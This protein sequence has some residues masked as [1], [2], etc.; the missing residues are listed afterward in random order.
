VRFDLQSH[1]TRSDG[2]LSP[3]EVVA[4]AR[5]AGVEL[6]SLTDHDGVEGVAEAAV[7]AQTAGIDLVRGVEI[8][9]AEDE[10]GDLHV[11]GY[12]I[13]VR[14]EPL[15]ARLAHSRGERSSRA[16]RMADALR[17]LGFSIDEDAASRLAGADGTVGRPHLAQAI[18]SDPRNRARLAQEG[19][20]DASGFL[21][22]Y[23]IEGK[24]AFRGRS[25]PSVAE[26]IA[27][28]H[29]AGG[30]A[31]WAHPF[32]D[33][34]E[35]D[36]VV[37]ALGRFADAGLDGVEAFYITHTREQ[38]LLLARECS[39]LGL[40]STGSSDFHGPSHRR[41]SRFLAFDTYGLQPNLGPL[42]P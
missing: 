25:A 18:A 6:L 8:S 14:N 19:L 7:A 22:A 4:A 9:A 5:A 42:V 28:I 13:D 33:I 36:R 24:P 16:R 37:E 30:V 15:R 27:L 26:T 29:G 41:F 34:D 17:D 2:S 35:P 23:L 10:A 21:E 38:T 39:R 40:L 3:A 20:S 31:V 11:L 12:L 1:S 32:W